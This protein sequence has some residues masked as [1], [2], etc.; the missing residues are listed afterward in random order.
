MPPSRDDRQLPRGRHGLTRAEVA[1]NQCGRLL[2]AVPAAV[3]EKGFASLTVEDIC[4]RAGVSRRTFYENFR[5]AGDCFVASC[6]RQAEQLLAV[7]AGASAAGTDWAERVRLALEALLHH[8]SERP[9]VAHMA[10]IEVLAAGPAALTERDRAVALLSSLIGEE[11]LAAGPE[12][13]PRLL[14]EVIAGATLQLIYARVLAGA[15]DQLE[16]LLPTIMYLVLVPL[17]GPTMAAARAGL[18]PAEPARV[19]E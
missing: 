9:D 3:R 16:Q 11:A 2:D 13:A 4:S 15:G 7:V 10:M 14:V 18:V 1:E 17:H 8:L 5:D 19:R 12:P 6:R